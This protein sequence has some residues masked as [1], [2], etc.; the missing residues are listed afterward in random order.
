MRQ[1]SILSGMCPHGERFPV[2]AQLRVLGPRSGA[3]WRDGHWLGPTL[4]CD[5][6]DPRNGLWLSPARATTTSP[7]A[8]VTRESPGPHSTGA[9]AFLGSRATSCDGERFADL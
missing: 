3:A 6:P 8:P 4:D 2:L 5:L 1:V 7:V 9:F